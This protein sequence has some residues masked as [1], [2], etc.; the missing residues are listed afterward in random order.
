[1]TSKKIVNEQG[2]GTNGLITFEIEGF[3]LLRDRKVKYFLPTLKDR[4]DLASKNDQFHRW[5]FI[6]SE[7]RAYLLVKREHCRII[8]DFLTVCSVFQDL[9]VGGT[10]ADF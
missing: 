7:K 6:T 1:M 8:S 3:E 4:Y 5:L 9:I 2:R 10:Y